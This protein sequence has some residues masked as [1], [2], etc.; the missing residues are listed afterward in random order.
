MVIWLIHIIISMAQCKTAVSPMEILQSCTEPSTWLT[1]NHICILRWSYSAFEQHQIFQYLYLLFQL[2]KSQI[3]IWYQWHMDY[4]NKG[5]VMQK[6]FS[7]H[8]IVILTQQI[9]H[10]NTTQYQ[11]Q[12][13]NTIDR[14]LVSQTLNFYV[15]RRSHMEYH[16]VLWE[17][18]EKKIT[19]NIDCP[20]YFFLRIHVNSCILAIYIPLTL[21]K[22]QSWRQR[23]TWLTELVIRML[24]R[25]LT[26][27]QGGQLVAKSNDDSPFYNSNA[28][29]IRAIS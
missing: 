21:G 16:C 8:N 27:V 14:I 4:P 2:L 19:K 24:D 10:K 5:H 18:L 9:T 13:T 20:L 28:T 26:D 11:I 12:P 29:R 6:I 1:H 22:Q 15:I 25:H 3:T 23:R 17:Y 7:Y